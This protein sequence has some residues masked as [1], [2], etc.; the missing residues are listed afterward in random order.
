M[1]FTLIPKLTRHHSGHTATLPM[2][3]NF[4]RYSVDW[5]VPV[6]ELN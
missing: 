6:T 2:P 4:L 1:D 3:I 5:R